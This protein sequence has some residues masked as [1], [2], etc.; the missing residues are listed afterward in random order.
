MPAQSF[1]LPG[2]LSKSFRKKC[3]MGT[4]QTWRERSQPSKTKVKHAI[5]DLDLFLEVISAEDEE[6][7]HQD[8]GLGHPGLEG[9]PAENIP[10]ERRTLT[11][12][13][14]I[15]DA[16]KIGEAGR[17][18]V[19]RYKLEGLAPATGIL[20]SPVEIFH[21]D[22]QCF[23]KSHWLNDSVIDGYLALVYH[24]GNGHFAAADAGE[25]DRQR[26]R[27]PRYHAWP[28]SQGF[29][30]QWLPSAYPQAK[31]EN[32]QHQF[33]P[34]LV[35]RSHECEAEHNQWILVYLLKWNNS[36]LIYFYSGIRS[37]ATAGFH[38]WLPQY[39][40]LLL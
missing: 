33:F 31:L 37:D 16:L 38:A 11:N 36:W 35:G 32:V 9:L 22:V 19:A 39:E 5:S 17:Q 25:G 29:E 24:H 3:H 7:D 18:I 8:Q 14:D 2:I 15:M 1:L 13:V 26:S 30:A 40:D 23:L 6:D 27:T 12:N 4:L 21:R 20:K 10:G 34:V 28:V